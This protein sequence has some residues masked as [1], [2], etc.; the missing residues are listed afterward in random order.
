MCIN[1]FFSGVDSSHMAVGSYS[2]ISFLPH[3]SMSLIQEDGSLLKR[4][5]LYFC[6]HVSPI[7]PHDGGVGTRSFSSKTSAQLLN[8]G[9]GSWDLREMKTFSSEKKK[10][11]FSKTII[12]QLSSILE[13]VRKEL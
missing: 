8:H 9:S 13:V 12:K 2:E 10:G 11:F 4:I 7:L 6:I 5:V 1:L 3:H